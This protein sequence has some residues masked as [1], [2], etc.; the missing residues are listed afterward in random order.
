MFYLIRSICPTDHSV[1][2]HGFAIE[3]HPKWRD[4]VVVGDM[5]QERVN[6]TIERFGRQWLDCC[7]FDAMHDPDN[8]G[9]LRDPKKPPGPNARKIYEPRTSI[10]VQWGE[11]GPEHISVPGNACGLDIERN[12][13]GCLLHGAVL[14]PHNVD[15]WSQKQLLLIAFTYIAETMVL[16]GHDKINAIMEPA[17]NI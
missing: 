12:G 15:S 14:Q 11:W 3:L 2:R 9:H 6:Q 13:F 5:N 7:G 8:Y 4:L 1:G 16:F 10:R 17:A